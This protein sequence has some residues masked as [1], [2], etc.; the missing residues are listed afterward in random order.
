[1]YE[2][3]WI[4]LTFTRTRQKWLLTSRLRC[5]SANKILWLLRQSQM[6]TKCA[7]LNDCTLTITHLFLHASLCEITHRWHE[8]LMIRITLRLLL[9][10]GCPPDFNFKHFTCFQRSRAHAYRRSSQCKDREVH[11]S[12]ME[13]RSLLKSHV[14]F[15]LIASTCN[16][17]R[18]CTVRVEGDGTIQRLKSNG[19][20]HHSS[21]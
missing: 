3:I 20:G 5:S 1:M 9:S 13:L 8:A 7:K 15:E 21:N 2:L 12:L 18:N 14:H 11:A 6:S 16:R 19:Y 4:V 10:V 17:L